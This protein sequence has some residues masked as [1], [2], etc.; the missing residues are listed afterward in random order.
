MRRFQRAMLAAVAVISFASVASAADMAVKAP[1]AVPYIYNWGGWYLGGNIGYGWGQDS[2][3]DVTFFDG[4]GVG[5][6]ANFAAGG[7]VRP[8][9][10]PKGVIGGVQLGYNW[11]V[12]PNWV[13]GL[14]A[15]FQGSG[16][17]ASGTNS[18]QPCPLCMP[19]T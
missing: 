7:N 5:L 6:A 11:M 15:D 16:V 8:N 18:V 12:G 3:P 19:S 17:K 9:V 4:S 14:V 13:V 1:V 10:R 2:D